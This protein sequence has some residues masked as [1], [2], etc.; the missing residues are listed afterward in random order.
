MAGGRQ[1]IHIDLQAKQRLMLDRTT[2]PGFGR[3]DTIDLIEPKVDH[4]DNGIPVF[5]VEDGLQE[6]QKVE[7]IFPVGTVSSDKK[8]VAATSVKQL[9]EGT[10]KKTSAE[11]A[12]SVDF[13]GAYLQTHVSHDDS[14]LEL[15]TLNKHL[16][17]TLD[18]L[19][20]VYSDPTF[21]QEE[22]LNHCLRGKQEMLVNEE[23]V[24]YLGAKAFSAAL[25]GADRPYGCAAETTDYG[26]LKRTDIHAFHRE[27]LKRNIRHIIVSG[28]PAKETLNELN[29]HFGKEERMEPK[30]VDMT[31][32][33]GSKRSVHVL[34]ED[35]V[36]NGIRMGRVMFNRTHPDFV[37]MQ[38]LATVLGGYFG[39]RLMRNIRE[40][41]GYTYG[42]GAAMVS[43][44]HSGY[45]SISAE[46]GAEVCRAAL[47]E[48]D[49]ELEKL[50]RD[51]VPIDELE[52]VR[53][54]ML[55]SIL[56]SLDG[57]FAIAS[58]WK[59]YLKYGIGRSA[60]EDLIRQI[61]TVTPEH[62]LSLS[63]MYLQTEDLTTVTVGRPLS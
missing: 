11:I 42:I 19:A 29:G 18:I 51:P 55:G 37:G 63:N 12:E 61:K 44:Q 31:V 62:L 39:S 7:L 36:Q 41:K 27:H 40:D 33:P 58:K 10:S 6:V 26:K 43:M 34:K 3:I 14:S 48:I 35:A 52:L 17:P 46:V 28:R 53:N 13:F 32:D 56:K 22:L 49:L 60:H 9:T 4:L 30:A 1:L 5:T 45:L 38:I 8:L 2:A 47:H 16:E 57:P 21:P 50:R 23:K 15:Y 25:F 54:Y 59:N 20:E 24:G